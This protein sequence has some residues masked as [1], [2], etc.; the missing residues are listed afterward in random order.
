LQRQINVTKLT[1]KLVQ[2]ERNDKK[3]QTKFILICG[4]LALP[5]RRLISPL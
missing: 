5:N 3:T 4:G 2:G 1:A